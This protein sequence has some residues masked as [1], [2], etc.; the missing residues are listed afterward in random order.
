MIRRLPRLFLL[1]VAAVGCGGTS[2]PTHAACQWVGPATRLPVFDPAANAEI[3]GSATELQAAAPATIET[4][5][6]EL[7]AVDK[8]LVEITEQAA[9]SMVSRNEGSDDLADL[10]LTALD[11]LQENSEF[12]RLSSARN[13]AVDEVRR[14][15][16]AEC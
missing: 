1:V 7:L 6:A 12:V 16:D 3:L 4:A 8:K 10:D 11:D 14:W 15:A 2:E 9:R 13:D 5:A